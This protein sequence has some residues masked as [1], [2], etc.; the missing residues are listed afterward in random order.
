ME[1]AD[2][3]ISR[4][5]NR[6]AGMPAFRDQLTDEQIAAVA[7]YECTSRGNDFGEV[8][9]EQVAQQRSGQATQDDEVARSEG[10]TE[11]VEGEANTTTE[12]DDTGAAQTTCGNQAELPNVRLQA[13][14][15]G[16]VSP[17]FLTS[18]AGD[19]RRFIVERTGL[20]YILNE[21]DELV[22]QPFL[23]ISD[24]MVDLN[25]EYDERGFLGLAF[26]PNY[27]ENGHFYVY[28]SAPLRD[29]APDN[30]NHTSHASEFTISEDD[31]NVAAPNSERV[32]LEVDQ[33][34]MN[35]NGGALAFSPE[36]GY[37]YI[38]LGDGG[39]DDVAV[40]HPPIGNG[41]DITS[42]LGDILRIDVDRG[43]QGYA[44]PQD[45][46]FVERE[47]ADEIYAWGW[48]NPWRMSFDRGGTTTFL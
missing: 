18:P 1:N 13:V 34:Q 4:I 37:L 38:S 8:T 2:Y 25:E 15:E 16:L 12:G 26:H 6:G 29:S 31:P 27:A 28:Y 19:S 32:L 45:N 47:G 23:D 30:W 24:R 7:S 43:Y 46:P 48:R 21:N 5:L 35:H 39:A 42:V 9:A 20:I 17:V 33:P 10:G 14:A 11:V 41:Q 3:H 36:D 22:E 40:G 44:I